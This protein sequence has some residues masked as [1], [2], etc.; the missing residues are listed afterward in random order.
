MWNTGPFLDWISN[1]GIVAVV[2]VVANT[3]ASSIVA[4]G[5]ARTMSCQWYCPSKWCS[6][7]NAAPNKAMPRRAVHGG[8]L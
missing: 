7:N 3:V 8:P 1:S 2:T 5:F 4:F 6:Q